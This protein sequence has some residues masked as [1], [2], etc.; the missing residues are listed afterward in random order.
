MIG[1]NMIQIKY[2][3]SL[4]SPTDEEIYEAMNIVENEN[5]VVIIKWTMFGYQYEITVC[6]FMTF[7]QCKNQIP[8]VYGL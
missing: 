5:C 6:K 2:F 8:T 1:D 7:E 4:T 3:N